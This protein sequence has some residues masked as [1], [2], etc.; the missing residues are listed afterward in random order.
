MGLHLLSQGR[1][2]PRL[3]SNSV[4]I[5][6]EDTTAVVDCGG[7]MGR[8]DTERLLA[9]YGVSAAQ[10]DLVVLTHLHFD[11]CG[12]LG[13]FPNA[14]LAVH[15]REWEMWERLRSAP[16]HRREEAIREQYAAIH[17]CYVR[18]IA[19]EVPRM[20]EQFEVFR[21]QPE[22]L[23]RIE[24]GCRMT[25]RLVAAETPGHTLGHVSVLFQ[26]VPAVWVTGDAVVS[27]QAW[28]GRSGA[29]TGICAD[30][31][32][33]CRTQDRFAAHGGVV[34]PGHGEPFDLETLRAVDLECLE[35]D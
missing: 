12:N 9:R 2:F 8:A 5:R 14:R 18:F 19:R 13:L 24:E 28:Q 6:D 23:W 11:H 10:V 27:L 21:R 29:M 15:W 26:A 32:A 33:Q 22:R 7:M 16:E 3:L 30:P 20:R 35:Q 4:L 25:P 34:V 1:E 31:D 17:D